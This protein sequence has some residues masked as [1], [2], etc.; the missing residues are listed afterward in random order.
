MPTKSVTL[1]SLPYVVAV[2]SF[3]VAAHQVAP[4][5]NWIDL[6][7]TNTKAETFSGQTVNRSLKGN[8]LPMHEAMPDRTPERGQIKAPIPIEKTRGDI[9]TV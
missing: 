1:Y 6:W 4:S 3:L 5:P 8:R 9:V 7:H 2:A